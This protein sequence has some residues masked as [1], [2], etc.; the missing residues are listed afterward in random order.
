M[1]YIFPAIFEKEDQFYNVSFPDLKGCLTFGEGEQEAY[2]MA[3]DALATMIE[4]S[5]LDRGIE[6][7]K[8]SSIRQ[9]PVPKDGFVSL[10]T[11][12]YI[13]NEENSNAAE[14]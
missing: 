7:P 4:G 8:A 2:Q 10:V 14:D 5:Y 11:A 3:A 6:L 12:K 9:I 1:N 13:L